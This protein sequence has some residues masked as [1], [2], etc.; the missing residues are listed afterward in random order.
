MLLIDYNQTQVLVYHSR[1]EQRVGTDRDLSLIVSKFLIR[2]PS[3]A[4]TQP[5]RQP[6]DLHADMPEP[7]LKARQVLLGKQLGRCHDHGLAAGLN[8]CEHCRCSD[9]RLAGPDVALHQAQ[10]R[11][12]LGEITKNLADHTLLCTRQFE[13]QLLTQSLPQVQVC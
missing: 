9:H 8:C 13:I 2:R 10:G 11:T 1:L 5:A 12:R 7:L 3:I 6:H 4:G